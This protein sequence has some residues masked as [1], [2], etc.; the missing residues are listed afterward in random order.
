[1]KKIILTM[2]CFILTICISSAQTKNANSEDIAASFKSHYNAGRFDSIYNM[3]S[4]HAKPNF[5]IDKTRAFLSQLKSRYGSMKSMLFLEYQADFTVY[6]AAFDKGVLSL[7]LSIDKN[8]AITSLYGRPYGD[9]TSALQ[10][11]NLTLIDLPFKGEWTVFWGGDTKA[12]NYHVV[13]KFQK[14]AF[15]FVKSG[16]DGKSYRTDGKTNEDYYAYGQ[17]LIAPCD[18]EVIV[19]V[20]G[21]KDNIPGKVNPLYAPGNSILLKTKNDEYILFAHI[22]QQSIRVKPGQA[23][24]RGELLGL[25][26]NSG[27]STEPHL[28]F[29]LQDTEYLNEATGIKCY[30]SKL[31][32]NGVR[33]T[34]CSPIKGD[35][36]KEIEK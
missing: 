20:D 10:K 13:A 29:H 11:R 33:K 34:D 21:V 32:V 2:L 30:F 15:D 14:N 12:L 16:R 5:P 27:N 1:M 4:E 18:A 3:F 25:C 9:N 17:Q 28:H 23:V 26:G 22:Q 35:R 36:I 6:K 19:T 24:K 7:L 8:N 31:E